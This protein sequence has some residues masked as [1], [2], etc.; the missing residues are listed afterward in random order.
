LH[1]ITSALYPIRQFPQTFLYGLTDGN[2]STRKHRVLDEMPIHWVDSKTGRYMFLA[3]NTHYT[4][5]NHLMD[6]SS[7]TTM[8]P[9]ENNNKNILYFQW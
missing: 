4:T 3:E 5:V 6:S 2:G 1:T 9:E 7:N 8:A